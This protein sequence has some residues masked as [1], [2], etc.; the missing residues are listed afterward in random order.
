MTIHASQL[1][2]KALKRQGADTMFFLM[3]GPMFTAESSCVTEGIRAI[4]VRHE[5]AAAMMAHAYAR[6]LNRPGVCMAASGPAALNFG[7]GLATSLMDCTPV[8]A[9]GGSSTLREWGT[10]A[11]QEFDQVAAMRPLTKW[12]ERV[13]E[14]RR[15]PELIN[16]AFTIAAS[17]KPGPVYLD[18]PADILHHQVEESAIVWPEYDRGTQFGSAI[19]D[20]AMVE[21]A[22]ALLAQAKRPILLSGSG[23]IWSQAAPAL[24]AFVDT[25]GIPFYTTP[26]GR[27]VIPEDHECCYLTARNLAFKEADVVLIV[28]T[29]INYIISHARAPRFHEQAKFIRIDI[30]PAEVASTP[31]LDVGLVGDAGRVI[32][33][34]NAANDGRIRPGLFDAWRRTLAEAHEQRRQAQEVK[35]ATDQ[36]PI[37]P[38]RLCKEIRDFIDRDA[39]L[40]VDGQEILNYGRQSIPSYLPGHRL[41]SG[42][43]GTMGVGLPYAIGAKAARP[44]RQVICLHGDGSFGVNAMEIDTA[45]RHRLPVIT[46]ISLNGG[47]M[48]DPKRAWVGR[49]LGFSRY[50]KMAEAFGC[51]AEYVE[52]PRDIRPALERASATARK[53]VPAVINVKTDPNAKATT[54]RF[55][56]Y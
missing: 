9:L 8:V 23:A 38:L 29:R 15:I 27:G 32:G 34:F 18:L 28:G 2:G 10:G 12:A 55:V 37:H 4:D 41:N 3:G 6:V 56:T 50:D 20:P 46:V 26:Q 39:I 33:Q 14:A 49:D 17:G 52:Q 30:D 13:Y 54:G 35:L 5:Q 40:V 1:V 42:T 44:D 22:I 7:T 47:W 24:R 43:F 16:K 31:R 53:G 19:G 48:S 36:V 11:F 45:V 21:R 25:T 51:Y